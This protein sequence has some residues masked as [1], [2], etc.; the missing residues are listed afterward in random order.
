M[1]PE[2]PGR[3]ESDPAPGPGETTG[4]DK[5]AEAAPTPPGQSTLA[6]RVQHHRDSLEQFR[7]ETIQALGELRE[8]LRDTRRQLCDKYPEEGLVAGVEAALREAELAAESMVE[9]RTPNQTWPEADREAFDRAA[10]NIEQIEAQL[11]QHQL[12][13]TNGTEKR[14]P[15]L[16]QLDREYASRETA[17]GQALA[18]DP[19]VT[20]AQARV[21]RLETLANIDY[22]LDELAPGNRGSTVMNEMGPRVLDLL[23]PNMKSDPDAVVAQA[24]ARAKLPEFEAWLD[25]IRQA[26]ERIRQEFD[27]EDEPVTTPES[28]PGPVEPD[29]EAEPPVSLIRESD[30]ELDKLLDEEADLLGEPKPTA[31]SG[32]VPQLVPEAETESPA[33]VAW[34]AALERQAKALEGFSPY[35]EAKAN[36][37]KSTEDLKAAEDKVA[38]E[39]AQ[40]RKKNSEVADLEEWLETIE[41]ALLNASGESPDSQTASG[42]DPK[43]LEDEILTTRKRIKTAFEKHTP[44]GD[45]R[46]RLKHCQRL[47]QDNQRAVDQAVEAARKDHPPYIEAMAELKLAEAALGTA[48]GPGSPTARAA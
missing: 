11:A 25:E 5:A 37:I 13:D 17:R 14:G 39:E 21:K 35:A 47:K 36:W 45:A 33:V 43:W 41:E 46:W 20:R 27:L 23:T 31:N 24:R 29:R 18:Q 32:E 9:D 1:S 10:G 48:T 12:P 22:Y 8:Q 7:L 26:N 2:Q 44:L 42:D 38:Q 3:S 16:D 28:R 6:D 15:L 4:Q 30:P 34:R 19:E 40:A